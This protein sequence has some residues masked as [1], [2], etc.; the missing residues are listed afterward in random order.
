MSYI[1]V[2][3]YKRTLSRTFHTR[4][5]ILHSAFETQ[6]ILDVLSEV[7][8]SSAHWRELGGRL[9]TKDV[10]A[11]GYQ[12]SNPTRCLEEVIKEWQRDGDQPSWE[13]LANAVSLCR[14]GGG[15][16]MAAKIRE[17]VGTGEAVG[18]NVNIL[19]IL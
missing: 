16:N 4:P 12:H 1:L 5:Y 15:K 7:K 8:F 2:V 3:Y 10:D 11:I 18:V 14:Q 13:T 9:Q 6:N 19:A 17:K